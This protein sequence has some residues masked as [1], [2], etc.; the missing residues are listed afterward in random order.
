[1]PNDGGQNH[2]NISITPLLNSHQQYHEHFLSGPKNARPASN[3]SSNPTDPP[4]DFFSFPETKT[5]PIP[6]KD[7]L[8]SALSFP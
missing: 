6:D 7:Y 4:E 1:M 8:F 5:F 2:K 3:Y